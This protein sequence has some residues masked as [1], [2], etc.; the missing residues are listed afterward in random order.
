MHLSSE[1]DRYIIEASPWS[2]DCYA[3]LS[4]T[5]R[6]LGISS[7]WHIGQSRACRGVRPIILSHHHVIVLGR[8]WVLLLMSNLV[9]LNRRISWESLCSFLSRQSCKLDQCAHHHWW[10][11]QSCHAVPEKARAIELRLYEIVVGPT[12]KSWD[13]PHHIT[14]DGLFPSNYSCLPINVRWPKM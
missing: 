7:T 11:S 4:T 12:S 10:Q 1:A 5:L 6:Y 3:S 2:L 9:C 13:S 8:L 14:I